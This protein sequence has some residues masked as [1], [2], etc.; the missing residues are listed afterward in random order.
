MKKAKQEVK[1]LKERQD[2]TDQYQLL[3]DI[4]EVG[5][6]GMEKV[7]QRSHEFVEWKGKRTRISDIGTPDH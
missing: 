2:H 6:E 4:H 7:F 5:H 1:T 3:K